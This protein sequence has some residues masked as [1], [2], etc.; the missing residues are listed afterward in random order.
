MLGAGAAPRRASSARRLPAKH[1]GRRFGQRAGDGD[2]DE[3]G[4]GGPQG[5]AGPRRACVSTR[6]GRPC[7]L[8]ASLRAEAGLQG[9]GAA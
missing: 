5:V 3:E 8:R 9:R 2:K 6:R 4:E 1:C 7:T